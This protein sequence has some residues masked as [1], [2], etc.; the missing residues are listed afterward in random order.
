LAGG[1][2]AII[3][4]KLKVPTTQRH[5]HERAARTRWLAISQVRFFYGLPT[6]NFVFYLVAILCDIGRHCDWPLSKILLSTHLP[7]ITKKYK[8]NQTMKPTRTV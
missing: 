7:K 5:H 8:S 1:D 2:A 4:I 3:R 6:Y